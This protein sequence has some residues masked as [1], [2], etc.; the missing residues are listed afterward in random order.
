MSQSM[1]RSAMRL[2]GATGSV[3]LK[4][5]SNRWTRA[6]K[7]PVWFFEEIFSRRERSSGGGKKKIRRKKNHLPYLLKV[8]RTASAPPLTPDVRQRL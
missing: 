1:R 3:A 6:S 7:R 5:P 4:R 8:A 2:V